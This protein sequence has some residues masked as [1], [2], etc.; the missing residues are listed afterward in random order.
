M[1]PALQHLVRALGLLTAAVAGAGCL[2]AGLLDGKLCDER[3]TCL[4]GYR[5]VDGVC[6]RSGDGGP[7]DADGATD[8]DGGDG[9]RMRISNLGPEALDWLCA[10]DQVL[11]LTADAEL[12]TTAIELSSG[13]SIELDFHRIVDQAAPQAPPLAVIGLAELHIQPNAV[14]RV[15]GDRAAVFLVCREIDIKGALD[16]SGTAGLM[17][18][19]AAGR[20]GRGGPG[21]FA[22]G[23]A[24]GGAGQG[25]G[26]GGGAEAGCEPLADSGGAGG[27]AGAAGGGGGTGGAGQDCRQTGPDGGP[28]AMAPAL[29]PLLGGGGGGGGG[30]Q[31]G[32]PGGG[33]GGAVQLVAGD[34]IGLAGGG[35][36]RVAG[37][38][39]AGGHDGVDSS[40]GG[41]GGAG[42]AVLLE[43]P[44][45]Q[46][47]GRVIANG[48]G[49][50][51]GYRD[52]QAWGESVAPSGEDGRD[53]ARPAAGGT[54]SGIGGGGGSGGAGAAAA[55]RPGESAEN[56][57]GGGGAAGR[58]RI[59]SASGSARIDASALLSPSDAPQACSG[60]CSQGGF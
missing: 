12:D 30:D 2:D 48:G 15:R 60:R 16:A 40:A 25:P 53:D 31:S 47:S 42:G 20:P 9:S 36:I 39:G 46:L 28:A 59:N 4:P 44:V 6:Q 29:V 22:G 51:A 49:G 11:R 27:G 32:G 37:G 14:L 21:G 45:V 26:G 33:G 8:G 56:G 1:R 10:S 17:P 50:G 55:G 54:G 13:G 3:G 18:P 34:R 58:I 57:G 38:G 19:D 23:T 41:G 52:N 7:A 5:C 43:A 24:G 35:S